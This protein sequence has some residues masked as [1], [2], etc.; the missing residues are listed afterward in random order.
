M[1]ES[2][3]RLTVR[4]AALSIE[5]AGLRRG[6]RVR[7]TPAELTARRSPDRQERIGSSSP[8]A[9]PPGEI[10]SERSTGDVAPTAS[11]VSD[12]PAQVNT[13]RVDAEGFDPTISSPTRHCLESRNRTSLSEIDRW[14]N[15]PE[16]SGDSQ[17][18]S[19]AENLRQLRALLRADTLYGTAIGLLL[20]VARRAGSRCSLG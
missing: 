1:V 4:F 8:S 19:I 12:A 18:A 16:E 14:E 20:S 5:A 13:N 7:P 9:V 11:V 2:L 3:R 6:R 15:K 10:P 17:L